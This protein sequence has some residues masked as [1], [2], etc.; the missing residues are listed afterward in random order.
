MRI[1]A[2]KLAGVAEVNLSHGFAGAIAINYILGK[3]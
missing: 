2:V 1:M 3:E